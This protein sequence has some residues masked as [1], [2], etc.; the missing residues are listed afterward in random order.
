MMR[1]GAT[2]SIAGVC[3]LKL[4]GPGTIVRQYLF[5]GTLAVHRIDP[6]EWKSEGPALLLDLDRCSEWLDVQTTEQYPPVIDNRWDLYG[7]D[8]AEYAALTRDLKEMRALLYFR[9]DQN[10]GGYLHRIKDWKPLLV[11]ADTAEQDAIRDLSLSPHW[12]MI[13]IDGQATY[14]GHADDPTFRQQVQTA[15][16]TFLNLEWP[17]PQ[18]PPPAPQVIAASTPAEATQIAGAMNSIRLPYAALH[19]LPV[20]QSI[21]SRKIQAWSYLELS[22]R[23]HRNTGQHSLLD[24]YRALTLIRNLAAQKRWTSRESERLLVSLRGLELEPVAEQLFPSF[25]TEKDFEANPPER[26]DYSEMSEEGLIRFYLRAGNTVAAR[27]QIEHLD[28]TH[29]PF[30]SVILSSLD[31]PLEELAKSMYSLVEQ[32]NLPLELRSELLFY[33]GCVAIEVGDHAVA[34]QALT[35]SQQIDPQSGLTPLRITYLQQLQSQ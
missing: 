5:E 33:L 27:D 15:G 4:S 19:L 11:V 28:P 1:V 25:V 7:Q 20:E 10:F 22:Y 23:V 13:G 35:Q 12:K 34:V 24:E 8:Y 6:L 14:F 31:Q 30:Y 21:E 2:L 17:G 16:R 29:R 3:L 18:T 26:T 9:T 32:G